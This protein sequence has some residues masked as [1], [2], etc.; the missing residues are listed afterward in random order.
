MLSP[1]DRL[2][3]AARDRAAALRT[4][5]AEVEAEAGT[6]PAAPRW[7]SAFGTGS[8]TVIA[9]IKRRSPSRGAI[10]PSLEVE[11]HAGAYERGGAGA[12]SV[13]TEER[14]FGGSLEDLRRVRG[15][16]GVPVLRKD[17]LVDPLQVYESRA[18]GASAV[19]LIVR[20]LDD[21]LLRDLLTLSRDLDLG[22]L[23]E[24]HEP[25]ELERA[26]RAGADVVG[27]NSRDLGTFQVDVPAALRLL[28]AI[29]PGIVAVAESGLA[30]RRDVEAA[31]VCGADAVLVGSSVAADPNP[32][33][34]VR[35]LTGVAR[36]V[37]ARDPGAPR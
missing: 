12:V 17:F 13:L 18:A 8:V 37:G 11:S 10:A 28:R 4:R 34:A 19:L 23:V 2:V 26:I 30:T 22:V 6:A 36:R 33:V 32:E 27:V 7:S 29:P 16:V 24:V 20:I 25:G 5:R 14:D 31:A 21:A 3:A 35:G 15:T 1:L 9:E